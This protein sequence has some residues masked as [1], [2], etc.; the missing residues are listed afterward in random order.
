[1]RLLKVSLAFFIELHRSV[2]L[3]GKRVLFT[4]CGVLSITCGQMVYASWGGVMHQSADFK[5]AL[6]ATSRAGLANAA[7]TSDPPGIA[8]VRSEAVEYQRL[9]S[10]YNGWY[11]GL[12]L[13][14]ALLSLV[15]LIKSMSPPDRDKN[16]GKR[17]TDWWIFGLS[18]LA[19]ICTATLAFLSPAD[20]A[21]RYRFGQLAMEK[22]LVR[23]DS[24]GTKTQTDVDS[25]VAVYER[26]E[27]VLR[28]GLTPASL[29]NPVPA[30][31]AAQSQ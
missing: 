27:D 16:T 15:T 21:N 22:A 18:A 4:V 8:K 31:P 30:H 26:A 20:K 1:M 17:P 2:N 3:Q 12:S 13:G 11:Y 6:Q 19:L 24:I 23:Y 10:N 7:I 5:N 29:S 25:V 9:W 28:D 14:A